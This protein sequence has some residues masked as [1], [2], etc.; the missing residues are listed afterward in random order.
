MGGHSLKLEHGIHRREMDSAVLH[1]M[2]GAGV[3]SAWQSTGAVCD[4]LASHHSNELSDD[5]GNRVYDGVI[6][7]SVAF[8]VHRHM[9]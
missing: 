5:S 8:A 3:V 1:A 6:A 9:G 2:G 4:H 7:G